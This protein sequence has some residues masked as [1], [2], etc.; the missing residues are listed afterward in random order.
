VCPNLLLSPRESLEA[1]CRFQDRRIPVETNL[2][3][4]WRSALI[5]VRFQN[6]QKYPEKPDERVQVKAEKKTKTELIRELQALRERVAKLEGL[7]ESENKYM[8]VVENSLT[9]IYIEQD[10]R[11]LFVNNRFSEI[12]GYPREELIGI[13]ASKLIHPDDRGFA[14]DMAVRRLQGED[15]PA[16]YEI[17]GLTRQGDPIWIRR[18]NNRI[19]YQGRPAIL[20]NVVEITLEKLS[21]KKERI[22]ETIFQKLGMREG[23]RLKEVFTSVVPELADVITIQSC[24]LFSISPD[25]GQVTLEAGYPETA[26]YHGVGNVF[27][28]DDEPYFNAIIHHAEVLGEYEDE[29]IQPSYVLITNPQRSR[30]LTEPLRQFAMINSPE[31]C[32]NRPSL[33]VLEPY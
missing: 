10:G 12:H 5:E 1:D 13:E 25:R 18:R 20:G 7:Q 6:T 32:D 3:R 2:D 29:K 23:V 8:T 22:I 27:S 31:L 33:T 9:G 28:V 17:K 19:E 30:L 16:N 26:S 11:I 4:G 15:L 21:A 14:A 24:A